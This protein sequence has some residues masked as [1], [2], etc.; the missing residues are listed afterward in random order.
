MNS[1]ALP[2]TTESRPEV[3]DQA[4]R[5]RHVAGAGFHLLH[6]VGPVTDEV[7]SFLGPAT[8]ALAKHG[9]TQHIVVIDSPEYRH[10]VRQFDD[11]AQ[12]VRVAP[13]GNP[14]SQWRKAIRACREEITRDGLGVVHVHGLIPF[15]MISVGLGSL[16]GQTAVVYSPHGSRSLGTLRFAGKI[17]MLAA[18]SAVRRARSSAIVT[19]RREGEAFDNWGSTDIIE[20]PVADVFFSVERVEAQ[21]PLIVTGGRK[22]TERSIE[23][24]TQLAVLLS[25]EELGLEFHWLGTVPAGS[26]QRLR[27]AN[28]SVDSIVNDQEC[29]ARMAAG[30]MYVAPWS[31]RGFPLFLVQAMAAGLPCV[32]LDCDQ[33]R[34]VID[35]GKTG[36]LCASEQEMVSQIAALVD[37]PELRM[38]MGAAA[39]ALAHARFSESNFDD[40]LLTAYATRW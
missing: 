19:V 1:S 28:V 21:K 18:H 34:E 6:V 40:K 17:A 13:A 7:F 20:N 14:F 16:S 35:H 2:A 25:D 32:A 33:H 10:N 15:L 9:H 8:R 37:N 23:V 39:R 22:N 30:W 3:Q 12:V 31:T 27:A 4:Q 38:Q 29:A 36:F 24:F 26:K 11:Y 5:Q